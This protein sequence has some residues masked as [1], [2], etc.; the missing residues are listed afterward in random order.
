MLRQGETGD[1]IGTFEGHKGAVWGCA[2][3]CDASKAATG[4]AD[5]AA[6]VWDCSSGQEVASIAHKH[7]VRSVDFSFDN[8]YLLTGSNEKNVKIFDLNKPESEPIMTGLGHSQAV[9]HALFADSSNNR[10]IS[11]SDDKSIR[12]WD[13]VS[14]TQVKQIDLDAI[15]VSIEL[16][17]DQSILSICA[18]R[19]VSFYFV[20]SFTK[21]LEYSTPTSILSST[22]HPD[23]SV[24]VCGGDDFKMYKYDFRDGTEKESF[25]G[26]FG[27]VHSVRF[28]PDGEIYASGSEDG[29][30]RLWQNVVGTTYGLWKCVQPEEAVGNN[31]NGQPIEGDSSNGNNFTEN[32]RG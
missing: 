23:K 22:L 24:F 7:I 29:T 26:H 3:T 19:T 15:P 21:I 10:I 30:V 25:K 11:A 14:G 2:L 8:N 5:F 16:S 31:N 13:R 28:S 12:L 20:D 9:R 6:K 27:P 32:N 18:G 17:S 4:A 1:W